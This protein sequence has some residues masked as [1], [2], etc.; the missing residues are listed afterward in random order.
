MSGLVSRSCLCSSLR[1]AWSV[2]STE[3]VI[4]TLSLSEFTSGISSGSGGVVAGATIVSRE[5]RPSSAFSIW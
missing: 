1:T 4:F 5:I 2:L 3:N